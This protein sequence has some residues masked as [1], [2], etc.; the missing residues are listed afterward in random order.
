MDSSVNRRIAKNSIIL[1][2]RLLITII[3][4]LW[5]SRILL[6]N[7]GIS[8]YGL[9]NVVGGVISMFCFVSGSLSSAASRY[10]T[11]N[12]NNE[13][14]LKQIF[15]TIKAI[16][17]LFALIIILLGE[18]V[19]LWLVLNK[20]NY[21]ENREFAVLCVYQFSIVTAV[22]NII[23]TPYNALLIAHENV[24]IYAITT[25]GS[26]ILRFIVTILIAYVSFDGLIFYA[27]AYM[28]ILLM[29]RIFVQLYS[30]QKYPE[31]RSCVKL[32]KE[33]CRQILGFSFWTV[34]GNLAIICYTQGLNILLNMFFGSVVNAARGVAVQVQ[35]V[36]M[37]FCTNFQMAF[38]PQIV[39]SYAAQE[40]TR[41]RQLVIICSKFSFFLLS[42]III[43]IIYNVDIVLELWLGKV[44][45]YTNDFVSIMLIITLISTLSNPLVISIQATGDIKKFQIYEGSCLL[46]ILPIAYLL[47]HF[48]EIP[49]ISVFIVNLLVL[50]VAQGIR[51]WIVLP[52]IQMSIGTYIR[53]VVFPVIGTFFI[54]NIL[55]YTERIFLSQNIYSLLIIAGTSVVYSIVA[56]FFIGCDKEERCY[57]VTKLRVYYEKKIRRK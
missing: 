45:E 24:S 11:Y 12:I 2:V 10:I 56:I 57:I 44:P 15:S 55:P 14:E 30:K 17:L 39:K 4:G 51:I 27:A 47:L 31:A 28:S 19:G 23:N 40:L 21:P 7:L 38:N 46:A 6:Q 9:Y 29:E 8:D 54:C 32:C 25:L 5:S 26:S 33:Y 52:R 41:M 37:Q 53:R 18:T 1:Y 34:N 35:A 50:V 16:H 48:F 36:V 49:P 42:I 43:P 20:L 3:I 22:L 13:V